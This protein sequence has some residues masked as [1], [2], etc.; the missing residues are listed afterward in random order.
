MRA[1]TRVLTVIA[2]LAAIGAAR[3]AAQRPQTRQGFWMGVGLGYGSTA[4]TCDGCTSDRESGL[5]VDAR[6]GWTLSQ[7]LLLGGDIT[8]WNKDIDKV[9]HWVGNA[10]LVALYYPMEMGGLFLKGG[11][12]LSALELS[13]GGEM[14]S[15]ESFGLT[16]GIG[17][18]IRFAG[19][20]SLTALVGFMFGG[21]R[22]LQ[23]QGTTLLSGLGYSAVTMSLGLTVH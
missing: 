9:N 1:V 18:D 5:A 11:A 20:F 15:G 3:A 13:S 19:N 8:M 4:F 12:G 2:A 10:T 22:D 16:A 14:A 17:Y 7:K 6:A 23:Y 21:P